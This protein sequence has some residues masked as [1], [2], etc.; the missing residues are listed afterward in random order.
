[1]EYK[2]PELDLSEDFKGPIKVITFANQ[3]GGVGKSTLCALFANYLR[4]KG[5]IVVIVD[6]DR[7]QSIMKRRKEDMKN[8][9]AADFNY[10]VQTIDITNPKNAERLISK[11]RKQVP[12]IIIDSPGS[13][14]QEGVSHIIT[15]ADII[16]CPFSF[17]LVSYRSTVDFTNLH[18]LL[19]KRCDVEV[20]QRYYIPN[21]IQPRWGRK[22]E[23][24]IWERMLQYLSTKGK[25][26]PR[27]IAG[28]EM[29]RFTTKV[30]TPRQMALIK[31]AFDFIYEDIKD[32]LN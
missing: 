4:E 8:F 26:T 19:C 32:R 11:G 18:D 31:D 17:D 1:M 30:N 24:Q 2:N 6:C 25:V 21:R 3:K 23:L 10:H 27:I 15:G 9:P 28:S 5:H 7:Q 16:I 13:A 29:T 14:S 20:P 12:I 22:Q